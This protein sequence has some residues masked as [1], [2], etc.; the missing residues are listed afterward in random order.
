MFIGYIN[1]P[2]DIGPTAQALEAKVPKAG[3]DEAKRLQGTLLKR[4][5]ESLWAGAAAG[6]K[7]AYTFVMGNPI[8]LLS[9]FGIVPVFPE[10]TCLN[11][12]YRGGAP[13]LIA[14]SEEEG[15]STDACGYVKMGVGAALKG[16]QTPIGNI[17]RPDILLLNYSGCQIYIHWWEQL[18][19]LTGAPIYTVDVP[20]IREYD[21]RVPPHDIDYV[22]GQLK[23]LIPDL[24]KATGSP[25]DEEALRE[26]IDRSREAWDLWRQCLETGT[27]RPTPFDAYFE[28]IYYM[29]PITLLRGTAECVDF[30]RF[31]LDELHRRHEAG[32]GPT[33]DEKFRIIFEGV[34]NY[35]YFK[36]FWDLFKK[37]DARCVASTYP[38]V[39]GM[40]D[41]GSFRLDPGRPLESLAEYMIHAYCNLNMIGRVGLLERYVKDYQADGMIIHAIKSCRSFS[42][43]HGDIREHF[44]KE[45]DVPTLLIESDHVDPRY[46][47][48]AQMRNRVDAFF[49]TLA[50]RKRR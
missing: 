24:E 37:W 50:L 4:Y 1:V 29:S 19:Y 13:G 32:V 34:P 6:R 30:Y 38:K 45:L 41:S 22:V 20:Y 36:S 7:F 9:A 44:A 48:E 8:E 39:A 17:P 47:S 49:E 26:A 43:G 27:L 23:E 15:Y 18:H 35:P 3:F 5:L 28:S 21:G 10:V 42:M 16:G 31:L 33:K 14:A 11:I 25:F 40:V 46:Y 12:S 2:G